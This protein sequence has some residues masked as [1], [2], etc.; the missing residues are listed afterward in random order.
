MGERFSWKL[1]RESY[2]LKGALAREM[3][4]KV[5][6]RVR[7]CEGNGTLSNFRGKKIRRQEIVWDAVH[8]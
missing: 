6:G 2:E 8:K 3:T 1:Q 7:L 4:K 5:D